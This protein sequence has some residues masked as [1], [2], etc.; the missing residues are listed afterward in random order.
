M[1]LELGSARPALA[2][3]NFV[4]RPAGDAAHA[5]A[6]EV[7]V[8]TAN[9]EKIN[10][11]SVCIRAVEAALRVPRLG[12]TL[13]SL[14]ELSLADA[15]QSK[16]P[17]SVA[18]GITATTNLRAV[19]ANVWGRLLPRIV[20]DARFAS[21]LRRIIN[22]LIDAKALQPIN[23]LWLRV[24]IVSGVWIGLVGGGWFFFLWL[25]E[26]SRLEGTIDRLTTHFSNTYQAL[27]VALVVVVVVLQIKL[28]E[29]FL[30]KRKCYS[31]HCLC[32]FYSPSI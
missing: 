27:M 32:L 26:G 9:G 17:A 19:V 3:P 15:L 8:E 31:G 1:P 6:T 10:V 28:V 30:K 5:A 2:D 4:A 11:P 20:D 14:A 22:S 21:V 13:G 12:H 7:L 25:V 18:G 16:L 23:T 29:M 24:V